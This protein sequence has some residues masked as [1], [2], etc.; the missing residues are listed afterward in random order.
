[1]NCRTLILLIC[2]ASIFSRTVRYDT[3]E[4]TES[5]NGSV[6]YLDKQRVYCYPDEVMAQ[7]RFRNTDNFDNIY[8]EFWCLAAYTIEATRFY[9]ANTPT[10]CFSKSAN[11]WDITQLSKIPVQC[12]ETYALNGFQLKRNEDCISYEYRCVGIRRAYSDLF[13]TNSEE[14]LEGKTYSLDRH[15][16]GNLDG[17]SA[18]RA[19]GL[20]HNSQPKTDNVKISY[21]YTMDSFS[22]SNLRK[23]E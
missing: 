19:F 23:E 10:T 2:L 4:Y 6:F 20:T 21:S 3:T 9:T 5:G 13:E 22:Y 12:E 15:T 7:F 18:L 17:S 1:M 14:S 8:Y 16:V 11:D